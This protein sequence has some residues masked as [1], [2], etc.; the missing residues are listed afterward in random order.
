MTEASNAPGVSR[1]REQAKSDEASEPG[2]GV[3]GPARIAGFVRRIAEELGRPEF[4]NTMTPE[5]RVGAAH[6][7]TMA[8]LETGD[9]DLDDENAMKFAG[10]LAVMSQPREGGRG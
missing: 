3:L 5:E 6:R 1:S 10:M 2:A 9:F 4:P 7:L 8:M